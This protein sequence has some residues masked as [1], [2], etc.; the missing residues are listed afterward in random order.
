MSGSRTPGRGG[1]GGPKGQK[2]GGLGGPKG[3]KGQK[4]GG[5][6]GPGGPRDGGR[7]GR[8]GDTCECDPVLK[9]PSREVHISH[10][11][12]FIGWG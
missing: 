1:Q 7:S 8:A 12:Q 4:R 2:R 5:P 10:Y 6:G 3:Q 11:V 9:D